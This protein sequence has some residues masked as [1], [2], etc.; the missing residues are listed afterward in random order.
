[1]N[2]ELSIKYVIFFLSV[3][4]L[5][6]SCNTFSSPQY[7]GAESSHFDG[8][9][10]FNQEQNPEKSGSGSILSLFK[11]LFASNDR[12]W[13]W[14]CYSPPGNPPAK[15]IG[16][17]SLRVT[18]IGHATSLIQF[19]NINVLTDPVW[20]NSVGPLNLLNPTRSRPPGINFEDLPKI[21]IVLISHNHYDHCDLAT[22]EHLRDACN[23][24]FLCPLGVK[25]LLENDGISNVR[26]MDW[27][28]SITYKKSKIYFVPSKHFSMRGLNDRDN[29]LWGGYVLETKDGPI[30]FAGDTGFGI[31][32]KQIFER[33][34][35]MRL[36]LLPIGPVEPRW[37]MSR[38]H[39]DG[40]EAV[41]AHQILKSQISIGIH[42]GTFEQ[43]ADDMYEPVEIL[44]QKLIE[45][46]IS[47]KVFRLLFLGKSLD[48]PVLK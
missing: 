35:K 19:D 37:F 2:Y 30:Y 14:F 41:E 6:N 34:G 28:D 22:L 3:S 16:N 32:F 23:P 13:E 21:D 1:M 26:E 42:F 8:K 36:S 31:H 25:Q 29:N 9:R 40:S 39:I 12:D 38:V 5:V 7:K 43:G 33:F 4:L 27:W 47:P 15:Y 46:K 24:L 45:E 18:Y 10:F 11:W 48:I 17:D 44:K 20:S